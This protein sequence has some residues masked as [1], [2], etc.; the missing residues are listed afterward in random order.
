M[1]CGEATAGRF[2]EP[3]VNCPSQQFQHYLLLSAFREELSLEESFD[4]LSF[5]ELSLDEESL[6]SLE[7]LSLPDSDLDLSSFFE[8][9]EA[10]K[11]FD[12]FA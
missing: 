12:F 7:E 5:E 6:E 4:E 2:A 8:P 9:S 3:A 10:D 1:A 11:V